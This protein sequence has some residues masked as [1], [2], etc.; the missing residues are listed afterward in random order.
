[1]FC[2]CVDIDIIVEWRKCCLAIA[3]W[4]FRHSDNYIDIDDMHNCMEKNF[5]TIVGY[6]HR[7]FDNRLLTN[8]P[9]L[10]FLV[11]DNRDK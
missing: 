2:I 7:E 10:P 1:M 9:E 11:D 3:W 5:S 4:S 8:L 6:I